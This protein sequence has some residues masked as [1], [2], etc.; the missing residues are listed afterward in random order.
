MCCLGFL[1]KA[2][3]YKDNEIEGMSFIDELPQAFERFPKGF[4]GQHCVSDT[5]MLIARVNDAVVANTPLSKNLTESLFSSYNLD[6]YKERVISSEE[7]R[8]KRLTELFAELGVEL[9]FVP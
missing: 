4:I 5:T 6:H 3:G 8:H 9:E 2:C 1:A 7:F